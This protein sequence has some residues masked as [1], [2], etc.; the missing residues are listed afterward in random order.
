MS[1]ASQHTGSTT[2]RTRSSSYNFARLKLRLLRNGLR[3][4]QFAVLFSIGTAGAGALALGGFALLAA[5]RTDPIAPDATLVV[6]AA[7]TLAWTVV[8]LLGF[9][10]DETLDPQRLALLPLRRGQ[11]LRGLL[12]AALVGVAPIA[13][14]CALCGALFGLAH[15]PLQALLIVGAI[16]ATFLLCIVASRTLIATL[17]P[18]LRSRRGRDLIVMFIVLAA[19]VP[20]SFRL[21]GA[22][23]GNRHTSETVHHI[24]SRVRWT[25]FGWGGVAVSEAGMGH[26]AAACA[27]LAALA[28]LIGALLVLW[29]HLIPRDDVVGPRD[30]GTQTGARGAGVAVSSACS[31][32][33]PTITWARSPRRNCDITRVIRAGVR[34]CS[35]P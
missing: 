4:P 14:A 31:R 7:I 30:S 18:L 3:T 13:T 12:A 1:N 9:G 20:Q 34:R 29:S 6:F 15:D 24:A 22:D 10:T 33:F 8:P 17:A 28:L 16:A 25:P 19:F 35:P 2:K 21:F 5:L 32:S 26:V 23:A 27:M 11:L